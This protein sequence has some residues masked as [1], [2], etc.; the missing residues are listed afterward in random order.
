MSLLMR[1]VSWSTLVIMVST[2]VPSPA[3]SSHALRV[4]V[5]LDVP[6]INCEDP[7]TGE[8]SGFEPDL[9]RAIAAH[10]PGGPDDLRF[11][12]I[13][14]NQRITA[15]QVHLVDMVIAQLTVTPRREDKV[16]F[17]VPYY[18]ARDA[19]LVPAESGIE[20]FADL[21]GKRIAVT[22]E[23]ASLQNLRTKL[24][25]LPNAILVIAPS[26]KETSEAVANGEADAAVSNFISLELWQ[27]ASAQPDRYRLIGLGNTFRPKPWAI[28]VSKGDLSLVSRLNEAIEGLELK[29]EIEPLLD[30]SVATVHSDTNSQCTKM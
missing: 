5:T 1:V 20:S 7:G 15:L 23:S 12:Q 16:D 25:S 13:S 11:V 6:G 22:T 24:L 27:K 4:G 17:S 18:V 26:T 19:I 29:G 9:A 2:F 3:G 28:A 21:A 8:I 10:L 14:A 30:A